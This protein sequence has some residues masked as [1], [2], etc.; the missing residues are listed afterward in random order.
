MNLIKMEDRKLVPDLSSFLFEPAG[1]SFFT[2]KKTNVAGDHQRL[3]FARLWIIPLLMALLLNVFVSESFGQKVSKASGLLTDVTTWTDLI[4]GTGNIT[5]SSGGTTGLNDSPGSISAGDAIFDGSDNFVG[6]VSAVPTTSSFT[7]QNPSYISVSV[8]SFRKQGTADAAAAPVSSDFLVISSGNTITVGTPFSISGTVIDNG[9]FSLTASLTFTAGS[10]YIHY[11]DGGTIPDAT[12]A[13]TSSCNITGITSTPPA[14]LNQSFGNINFTGT[15]LTGAITASLTGAV[16]VQGNLSI[17]GTSASNTMSLNPAGFNLTVNGTTAINDYGILNDDAD[18]GLDRFDQLFTIRPN[19][20]F[21]CTNSPAYE[22]RGGIVNDGTFSKTGNGSL[23]FSTSPLQTIS[24]LSPLD[25]SGDLLIT[26]PASLNVSADINFSGS[27]FQ[28]S[29][30]ASDP[31]RAISGT[32]TFSGGIQSVSNFPGSGTLTFFNLVAGGTLTKTINRDFNVS[33][34]LAISSPVTLS[35]GNFATTSVVSGKT[36]IGGILDFG[37]LTP[38]VLSLAGNLVDASGTI[39]MNSDAARTHLLNLGGVSNAISAINTSGSSATI[40]YNRL[41]D[42]NVF[43]SSAYLN[44]TISGSGAKILQ[45]NS[46]LSGT[47]MFSGAVLRLGKYDLSVTNNSTGAIQGTFSA[48]NMIETDGTGG[49]VRNADATL[50]LSFPVG[51]GGYFSPATINAISGGTTGTIKVVTVHDATAPSNFVNKYWDVTTSTGG[52]TITA[53]FSYDPSEI[54]NAPSNIWYKPVSGNWLPPSGTASFGTNSF[55]ISNTTYISTSDTYWTAS[56]SGTYYSYQT[57]DWNTPNTWTSDPS[58]TLQIGNSVPGM[59]DKV[60]I[61]SGRT[62]SLSS[63]IT[64]QGLDISIEAGAFLNLS[65]S[66]FTNTLYALRGQGTL[67]LASVNIPTATSNTFVNAGG[68]TTEYNNSSDFNLPLTQP[69]YNNLT[70][71]TGTAVATQLGNLTLYGNLYIKSGSFRINDNAS[72]TKLTLTINGN[73]TVDATGSLT[74]G[75]GVTN[76]A[77]TAVTIGGT[78]PFINYYTYFHTVIIKGDFTNNGTVRFTNLQYP[79][80]N[81]FPP[82]V[83]GPTSG[84]ASVYFQGATDNIITCNGTT[85]LYNLI[86][87]KGVDQTYKLTV[88]STAY[89]NFRL[90]G[91]NT[92]TGETDGSDPNTRKALWIRTGTLVL[93][94]SVIIP[95]LTEGQTAGTPN[96]DYYLSSNAALVLNGVDATVLATADDYREVNTAYTV[97]AADNASMG[98]SAGGYSALDVYGKLQIND[99]Y[100]STRESAGIITSSVESGQIII[101]G[102]TVDAKQLLST[103]GSAAQYTQT[104]GTFVLRGRFQRTPVDYT[105]VHGL[106]DV[107]AAT[108]N[109]TRAAN[110]I[111]SA[112]GTF[113]LEN[114]TN[115]F[116]MSGGTIR[117]YDISGNGAGELKALDIKSSAANI[118]VTG[119]TLEIIPTSGSVPANDGDYLINTSAPFGNLLINRTSGT[120]SVQLSTNPVTILNNTDL[121]SGS[122]NCNSLDLT[123][124]GNFTIASGTTYTTGTNTTTLN[125]SQNQTFTIN[126]ASPLSLNKLTIDKPAGKSLDLAGSQKSVTVNDLFRLVVGTLNDNGNTISVLKDLFNSGVH[127]GTGKILLTGTTAQIIDGNGIFGN[128]ELNNT[129]AVTAPVSLAA[130]MTLNGSLTLSN[131]KLFNIGSYNLKLNGLATVVS[132]SGSFAARYIQTSGNSGDGGLTKVYSAPGAFNFPVGVVN[133]T[134]AQIWLNGVPS[135]YGSITIVPVNFA[136]PNVTVP[137]RSLSYF[138]RTKSSGFTLGSATISHGY[139]Y[140]QANVVTG[141]NITEDGYVAARFDIPTNSWTRGTIADVD[142]INNIIGEPGTGS[143]LENVSFIDGDYTAGDDTPTS[144]FGVPAIFYSRI[145]GTSSG[146]GLWSD[147]NTWS[148]D[149]FLSI[150]ERLPPLS[151]V[152][153]IL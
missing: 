100:L 32:F 12:W 93:E 79:V 4:P 65:T 114:T 138:W 111:S 94:G 21:L 74:V 112:F 43:G 96:S 3:M 73:V 120:N 107:S 139:T 2:G 28:I 44:L 15:A 108:L 140:S 147:V 23:T 63:D 145:G 135:A 8:S 105:T 117:I 19:G 132:G 48:S 16:T 13:T 10:A 127:S 148:T 62:I 47:L 24:G 34:D 78:A 58:G 76:P 18:A 38:K 20:Q 39:T 130:N 144:P 82:T 150:Q 113:N 57:G 6:I 45:A 122:L 75:T 141:A 125:G 118:N 51:S 50:P 11:S 33:G 37:T 142:E 136:H 123:I 22:F 7:L 86:L 70:I 106:R 72:A 90:Y 119:G 85:D 146:I 99:G 42:Q 60:I 104:A 40:N 133:Y 97:L 102:G 35:L 67:Q 29:S 152:Q 53:T 77:I 126:L 95:S 41:G 115:I 101:N 68:G 116:T 36:T 110:G 80:Y 143:F 91:A 55:T 98:I 134:P 61:L 153:M 121:T 1:K 30:A 26:D 124:G 17:S 149:P 137:G 64:T 46:S 83:A 56:A 52:K 59:N 109:T 88:Y 14:G 5:I 128:L 129:A 87:D 131:D 9:S 84:A 49:L 25:I 27:T 89:K 31:F 151:L 54:G 81:A 103:S 92:L 66:R 69:F 71:N